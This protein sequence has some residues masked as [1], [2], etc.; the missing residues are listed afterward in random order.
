MINPLSKIKLL[1]SEEKKS[2]GQISLGLFFDDH[3]YPN[4]KATKRNTKDDWSVFNVHIRES[5][6]RY[7]MN[8]LTN[9][10]PDEWVVGQQ[11]KGYQRS[12][13]NKHIFLLN[14]MMNLARHWGYLETSQRISNLRKLSLGD[15]KQRFLDQE[16]ISR[17]LVHAQRTRHPHIYNVIRLLILTGARKGEARMA[18]WCDIDRKKRVWTVPRSKNGR[19]RRIILSKVAMEVIEDCLSNAKR[20]GLPTDPRSFVF[21]N[22]RT[23]T[24]YDSF[25]AVWYIIRDAAELYDVRIHDLRHTY[26]SL[27]INKGVTLYEVQTLLGH[28]SIQMT[29]RYAHLAPDRLHEMTEIVGDI[30]EGRNETRPSP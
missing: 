26:A 8:E 30:V 6:G 18:R 21:T 19:S 24:A 1:R 23:G 5:L 10:I 11:K 17:L 13:I 2:E 7:K 20:L 27:L 16:E 28:S 29:Q 22:P 3:F 14:R 9:E 15:Y 12:T 4:V 25:Y